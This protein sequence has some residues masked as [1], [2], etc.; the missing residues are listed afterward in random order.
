MAP[1]PVEEHIPGTSGGRTALQDNIPA[2]SAYGDVAGS[3]QTTLA[4]E[5][6][7]PGSSSVSTTTKVDKGVFVH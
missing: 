4:Y 1:L 6:T 3:S 2:T 5:D 7:L